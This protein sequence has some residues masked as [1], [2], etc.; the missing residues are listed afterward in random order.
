MTQ[1]GTYI[2]SRLSS[3]LGPPSTTAAQVERTAVWNMVR[4]AQSAKLI[5]VHAPA[6]FGKTTAMVHCCKRLNKSGV[7]TAWLTLDASDNDASRFLAGLSAAVAGITDT[8]LSRGAAPHASTSH[9]PGYIAIDIMDRLEMHT[10]P[11][12]LVLDDVEHV[13]DPTVLGLLHELIDHLPRRGQLML[14]SRS[15][16]DIR[17]GRLRA[18]GELLEIQESELRFSMDETRRFFAAHRDV[19]LS[20]D[21]L[22]RLF[23]KT[24]GWAAGLSLASMAIQR[25]ADRSSFIDRFSGSHEAIAEY[26]SDDVLARQPAQLRSFLLQ[27]S[28]LRQLDSSICDTLLSRHDSDT[29]LA[30]LEQQNLF[31]SPIEGEQRSYRF[32]SLFA[33]FLRAQ[34]AREMPEAQ[35]PLHHTASLWY[36]ANDRPVPAIDHA[37]ESREF[38]RAVTLL[39]RYGEELLEA[40]RMRLL[41]RWSSTI[42]QEALAASPLL[43]VVFAWALCYTRG[44]SEAMVWLESSGCTHSSDPHVRDHVL[45]LRPAIYAMM[46]RTDD[47]HAAGMEAMSQ[48]SLGN[49]FAQNALANQM[50]YSLCIMGKHHEAHRLLDNAR[51]RQSKGQGAFYRM[52]SETIEGIID[53]EQGRLRQAT[54]RFRMAVDASHAASPTHAHGNAYA[55]VLYA[56]AL[57]EAGD[58]TAAAR[59]L[60]VYVPLARDAGVPDHMV[61]GFVRLARIAFSNGDIDGMFQTLTELEYLGH[62]RKLPRIVTSAKLERAR[63]LL[64]QGDR[65]ASHDELQRANDEAVWAIVK[66]HRMPAHDV[67][68]FDLHQWRW[69]VHFGAAAQ[70]LAPLQHAISAAEGDARHR[71]ALKLRL[72]RCVAL[73]QSNNTLAALDSLAEVLKAMCK[74]GF[75]R[76]AV[77][78]GVILAALI[79]QLMQ[80]LQDRG[81]DR[82][83]PIFGEYLERLLRGFG[84]QAAPSE[85]LQHMPNAPIEP[86]TPKE[87]RILLLLREGY[88]NS[89]MSEKLFVSD[90]TVRT[91]LRNINSKLC[92]E[93]RTQALVIARRLRIIP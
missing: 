79:T 24:E 87:I 57:Y 80:G 69:Q 83:D 18:K 5:L 77:D 8:N 37:I 33:D 61:I 17:L 30:H 54:A 14:G 38:A 89:A 55:G 20:E 50:A 92:A 88:S 36:E 65:L 56:D 46:D 93:S 73:Q 58:L 90:S 44:P 13:Q 10:A 16:P 74:E 6:G 84:A 25:H 34:L 63:M 39:A 27:T 81:A 21:Q 86:L 28:I 29:V 53:L 71:R 66:Q 59:L 9:S 15:R 85:P 35:Q 26:L 40:G 52:Y 72:L 42:P 19:A 78:E 70:V 41:T 43:Q 32:H 75:I 11:F 2:P 49:R 1:R 31:L 47:A 67:D 64:M 48:L 4:G 7:E 91:H 82:A 3:K 23:I 51:N 76:L 60:H 45:A 22:Q 62:Q 12:L 68:F